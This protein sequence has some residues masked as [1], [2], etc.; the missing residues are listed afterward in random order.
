MANAVPYHRPNSIENIDDY[1]RD[2]VGSLL[3]YYSTS[4][5]P[6]YASRFSGYLSQEVA[7]E[8]RERVEETDIRS[9]LMLLAYLEAA[10]RIDFQERCSRARR[11]R[12]DLSKEL[13]RLNRV[14]GP[15]V[16]LEDQIF[17][18]WK[19]N[20]PTT[21]ALIGELRGAFKFRHW[22][23]HGRYWL[24]KLGRKFD[25]TTI[26]LLAETVMRTFPFYR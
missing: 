15:R 14:H 1:N 3:I 4:S 21:A 5:L 24:P 26:Y 19:V 2:T 23:A 8:M 22:L 7:E 13:W 17:E 20:E 10:F 12:D 16:G 6:H 9:S 18:A 11:K 25:Y